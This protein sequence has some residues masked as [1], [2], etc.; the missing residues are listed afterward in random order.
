MSHD[1]VMTLYTT[2]FESTKG[3]SNDF[4]GALGL[5]SKSPFS[6]VDSFTVVSRHDGMRR[7]YTAYIAEGGMPTIALM[8]EASTDEGNGIEVSMPVELDDFYTF[9]TKVEFVLRR[10]D[11]LPVIR[12]GRADLTAPKYLVNGPNWGLREHDYKSSFAIQGTV[13]YPISATG[14]R[15]TEDEKEIAG[16]GIDMRF[17]IG[18]LE[19]AASREA[20]QYDA[21]T[22]AAIKACI[23]Q[24]MI[25]LPGHYAQAFDHC[26][27]MW[28]ARIACW[29]LT[30]RMGNDLKRA[31]EKH[32]TWRGRL[33]S[34][35]E[36]FDI[37]S[38]PDVHFVQLGSKE[39]NR[40]VIPMKPTYALK[41]SARN[42]YAVY[43][44][45]RAT[46]IGFQKR[47]HIIADGYKWPDTEV[48]VIVTRDEN[49]LNTV[50]DMLG[51]PDFERIS[52][53]ELPPK[54]PRAPR[55]KGQPVYQ[56][57]KVW[58]GSGWDKIEHDMTQGGYFVHLF[59]GDPVGFG[60]N[61]VSEIVRQGRNL[62]LLTHEDVF[63][64]P[65]SSKTVLGKSKNWIEIIP[66]VKAKVEKM[67][68]RPQLAQSKADREEIH[69][70]GDYNPLKLIRDA[71]TP[72][73]RLRSPM[74]KLKLG[75]EK[76]QAAVVPDPDL[77]PL[78]R[79]MKIFSIKLPTK[80]PSVNIEAL[81][82][83]IGG[84]YPLLFE[85]GYSSRLVEEL[86]EYINFIDT[87]RI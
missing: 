23:G 73:K 30:S 6:Y 29:K 76:L 71:K 15:L 66:L 37:R 39:L 58:T 45:D 41:Y 5:G 54:A 49:T 11:P 7:T 65:A 78:L 83:P 24:I 75:M 63:G 52:D 20:L 17:E 48:I 12:G 22:I 56:K 70:Y 25:D 2:Y 26:T 19:V 84:A 72:L 16:L 35:K 47:M 42:Q 1:A 57:I 13:P 18:E 59:D 32:M 43:W 28:E 86:V 51:N 40:A 36:D 85:L 50:L 79:L 80:K 4:I 81:L 10:F 21:R 55:V 60:T 69:K 77:A 87:R 3:D 44:D 34:G 68:A 53:I 27:T 67:A 8:D 14:A 74:G 31:L 9:R 46:P 61:T 62:G 64:I 82:A 33:I 38:V